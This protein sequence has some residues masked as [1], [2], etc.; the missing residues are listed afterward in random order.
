MRGQYIFHMA[1]YRIFQTLSISL[2]I[3]GDI[4]SYFIKILIT[5]V[6]VS[7]LAQR[8]MGISR[9]AFPSRGPRRVN[10]FLIMTK[11]PSYFYMFA[12]FFSK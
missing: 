10:A 3:S 5:K 12:I 2:I 9:I 6:H 11:S 7:A 4:A 1:K 8:R